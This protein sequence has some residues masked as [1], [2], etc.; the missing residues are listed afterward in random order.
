MAPKTLCEATCEI[1]VAQQST[2]LSRA[3]NTALQQ[4]D[5]CP[6]TREGP[7]TKLS[8]KLSDIQPWP[9][10]EPASSSQGLLENCPKDEQH[11]YSSLNLLA[12]WLCSHSSFFHLE[13]FLLHYW[14][15]LKMKAAKRSKSP[16]Y[17]PQ[18]KPGMA[19][20]GTV[21]QLASPHTWMLLLPS[22]HLENHPV[23]L[24]LLVQP[25]PALPL[26]P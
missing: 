18:A 19:L 17:K 15:S 26:L 7:D 20:P 24:C 12:L 16:S 10:S 5:I 13:S 1:M 3:K 22:D 23:C 6:S 14:Q 21:L 11:S 4:L 25:I 2:R 8:M 9:E